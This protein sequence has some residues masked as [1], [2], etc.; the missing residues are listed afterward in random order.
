MTLPA[1]W[2]QIP[3]ICSYTNRDGDP[4]QGYVTFDSQQQV[5]IGGVV[6][7]PKTITMRLDGNG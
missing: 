5:V 4:A 2:T 7:V 3:V 6:I 1:S